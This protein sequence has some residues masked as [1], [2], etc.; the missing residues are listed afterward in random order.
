MGLGRAVIATQGG[1]P[2]EI[3][4]SDELGLLVP[5][6]DPTALA[7]AILALADDP[8]RRLA[9]VRAPR[10]GCASGSRSKRWLTT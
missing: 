9:S 6:D 10:H 7:N 1:G 3:I 5:P 8:A 4:D 2:S